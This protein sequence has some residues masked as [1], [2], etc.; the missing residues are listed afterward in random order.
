MG[1]RMRRLSG[2]DRS[3]ERA[4]RAGGWA[5]GRLG[6]R[7]REQQAWLNIASESPIRINF[8]SNGLHSCR[9]LFEPF[10]DEFEVF[11]WFRFFLFSS[12]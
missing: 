4:G 8:E 7:A 11:S 2:S 3:G 1:I 9:G 5:G 6:G 10:F 12:E